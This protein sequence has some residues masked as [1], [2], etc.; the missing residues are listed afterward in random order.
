MW[1]T[2]QKGEEVGGSESRQVIFFLGKWVCAE[3]EEAVEEAEEE[4][5]DEESRER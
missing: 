2:G 3:E 5:E 1:W 4:L